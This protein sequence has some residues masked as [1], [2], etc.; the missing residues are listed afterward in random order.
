MNNVILKR[1]KIWTLEELPDYSVA[2]DGAVQ[3]PQ[4]DSK[5]HRFSFDHHSGCLRTFTLATCQQVYT[6]IALGL[7]PA[8]YKIFLN[9]SD[10]DVCLA[11]WLL[12]N[13]ERI[14]EPLVKKIV[15]A[16]G[17]GDM[18]AGAI[19]LNG[20]SKAVEWISAPQTDSIRTGDYNKLSDEGLLTVLESVLHRIDQF[21]NGTATTEISEQEAHGE[22]K[23]LSNENDWV[24]VDSNDPHVYQ[25]LYTSGFDR[26]VLTHKQSDGSTSV[27]LAKRSDF[28][29]KFPLEKMYKEFNKIEPGWG[30]SSSIGGA[31]RNS[32]GS[33]SKLSIKIITEVVN[34]CIEDRKPIIIKKAPR[35]SKKK[36]NES[37]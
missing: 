27:S 9:D 15:E 36:I 11:L 24:L 19:S 1:G 35:K 12:K 4:I 26:I 29:D 8:K 13:P 6:S 20:M 30:G 37:T 17:I 25:K 2:L 34:A 7:E 10:I 5:N 28:I 18:H 23:I 33:R 31:P 3:S 21:V 32:D 16:V 22:F 14:T